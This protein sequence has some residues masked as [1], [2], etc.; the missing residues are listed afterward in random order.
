MRK[1]SILIL[2]AV[3]LA[4]MI[5]A[6][7]YESQNIGGQSNLSE[8]P[9]LEEDSFSEK[10]VVH[11]QPRAV[12]E[13]TFDIPEGVVSLAQWRGQYVLVNL[14]ATWCAPC[15]REMPQFDALAKNLADQGLVVV[16]L[17]VDRGSRQ[18][19][20][21]FLDELAIKRLVRG[22]SGDQSAARALGLFGLPTTVLMDGAGREVARLQGEADW[23]GAAA[24]AAIS[25]LMSST[26]SPTVS[27]RR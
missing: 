8:K 21:A 5:F 25:A 9:A 4:L 19:P 20:D 27:P 26:M 24:Q 18:K 10:W 1:Y 13:F 2:A 6:R 23:A 14:W 12:A 15:R 22:H 3:L 7:Q 16:A 17:S 11:E